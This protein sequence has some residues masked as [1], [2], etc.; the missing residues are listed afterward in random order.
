MHRAYNSASMSGS[1]YR[2]NAGMRGGC[3]WAWLLPGM[4]DE[5]I[6]LPAGVPGRGRWAWNDE[7]I[8]PP[9]DTNM[10]KGGS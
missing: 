7:N 5:N 2:T 8:K 3:R 6:K 10:N 1:Q 9:A 4:D